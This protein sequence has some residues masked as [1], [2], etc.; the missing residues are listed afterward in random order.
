M[1]Y[2]GVQ[3]FVLML[4][5][6]IVPSG[7]DMSGDDDASSLSGARSLGLIIASLREHEREL[8]RLKQRLTVVRDELL[9]VTNGLSEKLCRIEATADDL[10]K[11]LRS[12]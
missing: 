9:K 8:D 7:Y 12:L 5:G 11:R 1:K 4:S 6:L 2:F 3:N 10:E